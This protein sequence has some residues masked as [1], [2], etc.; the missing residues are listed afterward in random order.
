MSYYRPLFP[1][2]TARFRC[3]VAWDDSCYE[4]ALWGELVRRSVRDAH[5]GCLVCWS[6]L[7]PD[8]YLRIAVRGKVTGAH[9]FSYSHNVGVIPIGLFVCHRCDNRACIEPS[10]LF[11]GSHADNMADMV[12]K[13][14]ARRARP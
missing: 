13:G 1:G 4:A 14:R 7:S 5:S 12:S 11:V 8:G 6:T 2:L 3:G 9:R 10:H